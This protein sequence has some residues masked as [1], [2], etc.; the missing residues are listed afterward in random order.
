MEFDLNLFLKDLTPLPGVYLMFGEADKVLYVGKAKNLRNR[1]SSYFRIIHASLKTQVLV[2]KIKKIEVTLKRTETEALLLEQTLIKQY[3]PPYN[4]SLRD[5]KSYPYL[6]I[7]KKHTFPRLYFKR[8]VKAEEGKIFGPFVSAYALRE[9][10]TWLQKVFQVRTCE[11]SFFSHRS[12]PCL[13]HQIKRCTA[14]CVGLV[15]ESDY[16]EQI[17]HIEFILSGKPHEVTQR[18]QEKMEAAAQCYEYE[19]A[20]DYRNQLSALKEVQ[21][22][23]FVSGL[24]GSADIFSVCSHDTQVCI[25]L[26]KVRDGKMVE[27]RPFFPKNSQA[28]NDLECLEG[29]IAQYYFGDYFPASLPQDIVL[30]FT[31]PSAQTLESAFKEQKGIAVSFCVAKQG[32]KLGWFKIAELNAREQ[33]SLWVSGRASMLA[34]FKAL[35]AA[36]NLSALPARIECFDVSHTQGAQT[37]ASCVVFDQE[38]AQKKY[39][40]RFKIENIQPGDDYAA[41]EQ[42]LYRR[43]KQ[44]LSSDALLVPDVVIVDGGK[45]QLDVA[46]KVLRSLKWHPTALLGIAKGPMRKAG[47]ETILL[48]EGEESIALNIQGEALFLLQQIRDEAHRFALFGHRK[49]REKIQIASVLDEIEGVG[50]KRRSALLKYFGGIQQLSKAS[51][52]DIAKVTGISSALARKI[53]TQIHG[54]SSDNR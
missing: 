2:E 51:S 12:R 28:L 32:Q 26:I 47:L 42:C 27:S 41:M 24:K 9:T 1:V 20:A 52:E 13:Q 16:Q 36:L 49:R 7:S 50:A 30:P 17:K 3:Q 34:R 23:Q 25:I 40:R 5:G 19:K 4:I 35:A 29:F 44:V 33:L 15:S 18:L 54:V 22:S 37:T 45:G 31:L 48:S 21:A 53:Y 10:H 43:Y 11:D 6:V 14:P 39:Y 8:S 38:G 46:R